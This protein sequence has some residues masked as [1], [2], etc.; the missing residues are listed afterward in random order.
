[1]D[2]ASVWHGITTLFVVCAVVVNAMGAELDTVRMQVPTAKAYRLGG[3][4]EALDA[5]V[6]FSPEVMKSPGPWGTPRRNRA[7]MAFRVYADGKVAAETKSITPHDAAIAPPMGWT[8]WNAF[9]CNI[10]D[11][12][13]RETARLIDA[14]GLADYGWSFV[15]LDDG[16]QRR[17][18]KSKWSDPPG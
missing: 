10:T 13:I 4:A 11:A 8:S 7:R 3:K 1:M 5:V 18:T 2:Y 6:G 14:L 16:W 9:R 12:N 17:P 15:N